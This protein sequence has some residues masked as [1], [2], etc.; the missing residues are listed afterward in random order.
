ML[1]PPMSL[2]SRRVSKFNIKNLE[3]KSKTFKITQNDR[4]YEWK[5]ADSFSSDYCAIYFVV[6]KQFTKPFL[7]ECVKNFSI[8]NIQPK[9]DKWRTIIESAIEDSQLNQNSSFYSK[10]NNYSMLREMIKS[11][12]WE[13]VKESDLRIKFK[14]ARKRLQSHQNLKNTT[15]SKDTDSAYSETKTFTERVNSYEKLLNSIKT[16]P[17]LNKHQQ[18]VE[19]KEDTEVKRQLFDS[20]GTSTD[21]NY[22]LKV[23]DEDQNVVKEIEIV[24]SKNEE[25]KEPK[26]QSVIFAQKPPKS[27]L[28]SLVSLCRK[29]E[30]IACDVENTDNKE[31]SKTLPIEN[32]SITD[33]RR[34]HKKEHR[35]DNPKDNLE[36]I[37]KAL[38]FDS[39]TKPENDQEYRIL[40]TNPFDFSMDNGIQAIEEASNE[41]ITTD[42]E[43]KELQKND[44][45]LFGLPQ[46][47]INREG[48]QTSIYFIDNSFSLK[49][50]DCNYKNTD[51]LQN[52]RSSISFQRK[53][54]SDNKIKELFN[55]SPMISSPDFERNN[56]YKW[57]NKQDEALGKLNKYN[58]LD[59]VQLDL[60]KQSEGSEL[61]SVEKIKNSE[62][63]EITPPASVKKTKKAFWFDHIAC[64]TNKLQFKL[65]EYEDMLIRNAFDTLKEYRNPK[66]VNLNW[67]KPACHALSLV[68][69]TLHRKNLLQS[70]TAIYKF[71]PEKTI[72][73]K[74]IEASQEIS[75]FHAFL[76]LKNSVIYFWNN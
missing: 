12:S 29:E 60:E 41:T 47:T 13:T 55:T 28:F 24:L 56:R 62:K 3:F 40:F 67:L 68:F 6:H 9:K 37:S 46:T 35:K 19:T 64:L 63:I 69:K 26:K 27:N 52:I 76:L 48:N 74:T 18:R 34:K 11:E 38:A 39:P 14:D 73:N 72:Q 43:N 42:N 49:D 1:K 45:S 8:T 75:T 53:D 31:Y 25:T 50:Q 57:F 21:Q 33:I 71:S 70:F 66:N 59:S 10:S 7:R 5:L 4:I 54:E 30:K 15:V 20:F 36:Y 44:D 58:I 22:T 2:T 51:D 65:Q 32:E 16:S 17:L 23:Q 61:S